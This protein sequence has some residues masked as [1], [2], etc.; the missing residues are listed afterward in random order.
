MYHLLND[1]IANDFEWGWRS[2]LLFK[3]L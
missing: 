3:P 2:L 1:A